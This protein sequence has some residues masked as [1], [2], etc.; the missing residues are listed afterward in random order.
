M[1]KIPGKV[2]K[3][4]INVIGT[5]IEYDVKVVSEVAGMILD[6]C[7]KEDYSVSVRKNGKSAGEFLGDNIKKLS[8]PAGKIVNNSI[9]YI[10]KN[11]VQTTIIEMNEEGKM[12]EKK[13]VPV[14]YEV[15]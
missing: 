14:D 10:V 15:K 12:V 4:V 1:L 13:Y 7:N 2:V 3:G 5:V 9:D 11:A 8:N 6:V